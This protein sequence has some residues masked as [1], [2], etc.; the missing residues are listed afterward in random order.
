MKTSLSI[1]QVLEQ[2]KQQVRG[3]KAY[4]LAP[5]EAPIKLNQ[6]ENPY[7][8]PLAIRDEVLAR[9]IA[10]DWAR[11]PDFVPTRL[12]S[13]LATYAGWVPDGVMA[14]NGSNEMI[15]SVIQAT[16]EPGKTVVL[17]EPTFSVYRQVIT[18]AG[19]EVH[20][21]PLTSNLQFDV[22]GLL[23]AIG[24]RR[25]AMTILCSPNNP[26]GSSL[27]RAEVERFLIEAA[28]GLV[29]VDQAYLEIGGEDVAPL[30]R[31]HPNLVI[32]RTFSKAMAMGGLRVGYCLADPA[33]IR[34]FNKAK[35]PY[36]LNIFSMIAAEVALERLDLLGPLVEAMAAEKDRLMTELAKIP[37]LHPYPSAANFLLVEVPIPP[38]ELFARLHEQGIL[39]RDLSQS[40]LLSR[41]LRISV[42]T[43]EENRQLLGALHE[44]LLE[45][46]E[47]T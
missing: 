3:I 34:E 41:H 38:G 33:L 28:P 7:G 45:K 11:Y 44:I 24:S 39:V 13:Q 18:V 43:P 19:G 16:I 47:A 37:G 30:L 14:G 1:D 25:P 40:P 46:G 9:I 27:T 35:M 12:L 31:D 29:V 36:S 4:T 8:V 23:A 20:S 5:L 15:Q 42:G 26:T 10:S 22:E 32:L 2:V 6:N 21:V 17:P